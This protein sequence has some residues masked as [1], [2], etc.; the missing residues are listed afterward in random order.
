M[1]NPTLSAEMNETLMHSYSCNIRFQIEPGDS[2]HF[3]TANSK[4]EYYAPSDS[5]LMVAMGDL[6]IW[7][8]CLTQG[9]IPIRVEELRAYYHSVTKRELK[10]EHI[11]IMLDVGA[12]CTYVQMQ[13]HLKQPDASVYDV[14]YWSYTDKVQVY[15]YGNENGENKTLIVTFDA[16]AFNDA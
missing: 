5:C 12:Y 2:T 7:N 3:V 15:G 8:T 6:D 16:D 10:P 9:L 4:R 14:D 11:A 13:K 1:L